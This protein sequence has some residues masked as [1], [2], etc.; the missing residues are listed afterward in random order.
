M[1]EVIIF[2]KVIFLVIFIIVAMYVLMF[3]CLAV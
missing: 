3:L 2:A 1:E